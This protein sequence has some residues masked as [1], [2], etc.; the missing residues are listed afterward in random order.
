MHV[1]TDSPVQIS[2]ILVRATVHLPG[3][4]VGQRVWTDPTAPYVA[5]CLRAGYVVQV[6][7]SEEER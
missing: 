3:L 7:P 5:M 6:S 1:V 4:A 2:P